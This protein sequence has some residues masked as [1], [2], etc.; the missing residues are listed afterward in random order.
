ML[1]GLGPRRRLAAR[2]GLNLQEAL[3]TAV[4]AVGIALGFFFGA[5]SFWT[6]A[7]EPGVFVDASGLPGEEWGAAAWLAWTSRYWVPALL[8]SVAVLR[9]VLS[10]LYERVRRRRAARTREV[11]ATG[12]R[13]R[14]EVTEAAATGTEIMGR[15]RIRFVVK[16]TDHTGIDRWVTKTG[17]FDRAAPPRPGDRAVVWFDPAAPGDE[18][19][20]PVVLAAP[21]ALDGVD[22]D[23]AV[24]GGG[25]TI[26]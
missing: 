14:G 8:L 19:A 2:I 20:I 13:T 12:R 3:S 21:A 18:R 6:P 22:L 4:V 26:H 23:E 24:A 25:L 17:L 11:L 15:P 7:P 9:I 16:F 5:R 1:S 10:L